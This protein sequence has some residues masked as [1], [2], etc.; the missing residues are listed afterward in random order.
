MM[1]VNF[2][3]DHC[4]SGIH[5]YP[6]NKSDTIHCDICNTDGS[7]KFNADHEKSI[8][9]DCP[10]CD[11]KDFYSQSD[12]NRKIGV[13][14]YLIPTCITIFGNLLWGIFSFFIFWLIDFFLFQK[15]SKI[16]I[17]YKCNTI[18]RRCQNV[19]D[20]EP[21]NHEMNDRI[22]YSDHDFEGKPLKH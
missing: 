4:G 1:T 17:C 15:I 8:V 19:A 9:K 5:V 14:L 10:K 21:F 18:F 20:I 3:C 2:T 7:V 13:L 11:R 6:S 12:F 16:V 22:I